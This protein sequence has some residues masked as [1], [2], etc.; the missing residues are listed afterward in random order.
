MYSTDSFVTVIL[1]EMLFFFFFAPDTLETIRGWEGC[2]VRRQGSWQ[3]VQ[4]LKSNFGILVNH[5][6]SILTCELCGHT[7]IRIKNYNRPHTFC[8]LKCAGRFKTLMRSHTKNCKQCGI[9]IVKTRSE[10]ADSKT[11]NFFCTQ[12]C[13]AVY[14]NT[15]KKYGT[16]RSKLEAWLEKE[17]RRHF[18]EIGFVFNGKE[19]IN[20]ELD[21]FIPELKLAFELNGIFH[22]EPIYG[23][24]KLTNI[25]SN[26]QRKFAAC[27]EHNISLCIIDTSRFTYFKVE[28]AMV[29]FN[30]IKEKIEFHAHIVEDCGGMINAPEV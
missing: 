16:R 10:M 13:A 17:L 6:H 12:S 19:A 9:E 23:N 24:E 8:D 1:D 20:S 11:G 5:M 29:F 15:H 2:Q 18:P 14:N 3:K 26:D 28:K 25:Q 4:D 22:Y 30:I 27:H 21:I 7:F